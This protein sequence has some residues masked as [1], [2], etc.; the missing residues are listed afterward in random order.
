MSMFFGLRLIASVAGSKV[1][2]G[3]TIVQTG[4]QVRFCKTLA[5]CRSDSSHNACR[6]SRMVA[7]PSTLFTLFLLT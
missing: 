5:P 7:V 2:L 1:I 6:W 3:T 4:L